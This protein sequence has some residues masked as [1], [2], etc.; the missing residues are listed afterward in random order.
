M[1][2]LGT[3]SLRRRPHLADRSPPRPNFPS[4]PHRRDARATGTKRNVLHHRVTEPTENA[5]SQTTPNALSAVPLVCSCRPV[6]FRG[7]QLEEAETSPLTT[8]LT[9][10]Q[11]VGRFPDM[12][13]ENYK[14]RKS[15]FGKQEVVFA[16]ETCRQEVIFPLTAAGSSHPCPSCAAMCSV[17]GDL[18]RNQ[19]ERERAKK[20]EANRH[21]IIEAE[22]ARQLET[23]QRAERERKRIQEASRTQARAMPIH[24]RRSG[25]TFSLLGFLALLIGIFMD[26]S[27]SGGEFGRVH[28]LSKAHVQQLLC[29]C[30]CVAMVGGVIIQSL[31]EI[32]RAL[33]KAE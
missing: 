15:L 6:P 17:P 10:S 33:T 23:Q 19:L 9:S 8:E 11:L 20:E 3:R 14:V 28:N 26:T 4:P 32:Q 18:E 29:I 1:A 31:A 24:L 25:I 7:V 5:R 12:A 21:A 27:A 22:A 13:N 16:C 30:G 2:T